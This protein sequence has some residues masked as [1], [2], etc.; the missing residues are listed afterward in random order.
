[1]IGSDESW[2][3]LSFFSGDEIRND[4]PTC[5]VS[6]CSPLHPVKRKKK[7]VG[8][9]VGVVHNYH[10]WLPS[11]YGCVCWGRSCGRYPRCCTMADLRCLRFWIMYLDFI[12]LQYIQN[13]SQF[14]EVGLLQPHHKL[15]SNIVQQHLEFFTIRESSNKQA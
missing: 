13:V 12:I 15:T 4:V 14:D 7:N 3:W 9:D 2:D 6:F 8:V 1:M 11:I 10:D 5:V